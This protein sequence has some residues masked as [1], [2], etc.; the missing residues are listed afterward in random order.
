MDRKEM[1]GAAA[2]IV[3]AVIGMGSWMDSGMGR[4]NDNLRD[5][6]AGLRVSVEAGDREL[7]ASI[8]AMDARLDGIDRRLARV[9]GAV[10]LGTVAIV[11]AAPEGNDG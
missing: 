10:G 2:V 11:P 4:L 6:I 1:W 3:A 8:T 7:R 5:A 9:E